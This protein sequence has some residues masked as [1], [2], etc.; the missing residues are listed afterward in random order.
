MIETYNLTEYD[1]EVTD[2]K[3]NNKGYIVPLKNY[4]ISSLFGKRE[5]EFHRGLD[6]AA[7]Q[8]EP[9]YASKTGTVIKAEFH[10]S[11]GN[12][13]AIEHEDGTT[14]LYA[15]QQEY[16]VEVGDHIKQGQIIGFVGSTGNS[17]GSHLHFELCIDNT[18]VQA[19]LIDPK[20]VLF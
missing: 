14:A 17:T 3:L 20:T 9:I 18:L 7:A 6:L 11:W 12:Y 1:Q 13:V 16:Q 10:P 4:T 8:G 5:G 2:P 15:H 19:Q